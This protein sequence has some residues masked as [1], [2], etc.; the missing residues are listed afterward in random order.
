MLCM[1][2]KRL[3]N[4]LL[5]MIDES[6]A[7]LQNSMLPVEKMDFHRSRIID[8]NGLMEILVKFNGRYA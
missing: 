5:Q 8:S 1:I 3:E 4:Y 7:E 6:H 2:T